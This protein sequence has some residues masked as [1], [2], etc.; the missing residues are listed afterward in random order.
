MLLSKYAIYDTKK[1]RF[2]KKQ[3]ANGLLTSLEIKTT[4]NKIPL[5]GNCFVLNAI[6]LNAI[7]LNAISLNDLIVIIIIL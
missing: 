4:L 2:I 3:E 5:L 7:S 1:S 6:S